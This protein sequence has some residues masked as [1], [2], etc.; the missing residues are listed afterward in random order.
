MYMYLSLSVYLSLFLSLSLH[1]SLY[2]SLNVSVFVIVLVF[3][4]VFFDQVT[5]SHHSDQM[6]KRSQVSGVTLSLCF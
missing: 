2:L 6:S 3:V 4:I 5:S 1:L